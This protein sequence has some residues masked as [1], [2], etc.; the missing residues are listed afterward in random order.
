[1]FIDNDFENECVR[2]RFD[3]PT[4]FIRFLEKN[5]VFINEKKHLPT[6]FF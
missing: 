5:S 4:I 1:M 6:L 2:S 3:E